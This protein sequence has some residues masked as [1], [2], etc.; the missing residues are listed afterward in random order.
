MFYRYTDGA[1]AGGIVL[2]ESKEKAREYVLNRY[3]IDTD[4]VVDDLEVWDW[5]E[6]E[7]YDPDHPLVFE[8]Y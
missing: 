1:T 8:V 2:A 5:R 6:D 3:S 7:G 4:F